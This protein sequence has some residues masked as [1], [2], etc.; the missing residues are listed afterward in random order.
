M[1]GACGPVGLGVSAG[2]VFGGDNN[3]TINEVPLSLD[4]LQA[5]VTVNDPCGLLASLVLTVNRDGVRLTYVLNGGAEQ[6]FTDPLTGNPE[7]EPAAEVGAP[8][9]VLLQPGPNTLVVRATSGADV[10]EQTFNFDRTGTDPVAYEFEPIAV[11][12]NSLDLSWSVPAAA[13]DER[14]FWVYF[15]TAGTSLD[16]LSGTPSSAGASPLRL[17]RQDLA[18]VLVGNRR[19]Y[20]LT[21]EG[22]PSG[23]N[24]SLASYLV[25]VRANDG[26]ESRLVATHTRPAAL[27]GRWPVATITDVP[28]MPVPC[29]GTTTPPPLPPAPV[30]GRSTANTAVGMPPLIVDRG[31]D[32]G[33]G[34]VGADGA[35]EILTVDRSGQLL[36]HENQGLAANGLAAPILVDDVDDS[37]R[38]CLGAGRITGPPIRSISF[39]QDGDGRADVFVLTPQRIWI[40]FGDDSSENQSNTPTLGDCRLLNFKKFC[41]SFVNI[42]DATGWQP[43]DEF[44]DFAVADFDGDGAFDIAATIGVPETL[45]AA[46]SAR[47]LHYWFANKDSNGFT[48]WDWPARAPLTVPINSAHG[49]DGMFVAGDLDGDGRDDILGFEHSS[50]AIGRYRMLLSRG[51]TQAPVALTSG[52]IDAREENAR[53]DQTELVDVDDDGH[54]DLVSLRADELGAGLGAVTRAMIYRIVPGLGIDT[55]NPLLEFNL[56]GRAEGRQRGHLVVRDLDGDGLQDFAYRSVFTANNGVPFEESA[57]FYY[58]GLRNP[59]TGRQDWTSFDATVNRIDL[60]L[61]PPQEQPH[62]HVAIGDLDADGTLDFAAVHERTTPPHSVLVGR[63]EPT[64]VYDRPARALAASD[65]PFAGTLS[66]G[67]GADLALPVD[68]GRAIITAIDQNGVRLLPARLDRGVPSGGFGAESTLTFPTPLS[69][70]L[71][72]VAVGE[73][74]G[75]SLVGL[76][77]N[78]ALVSIRVRGGAATATEGGSVALQAGAR[79]F[80]ARLDRDRANDAVVWDGAQTIHLAATVDPAGSGNQPLRIVDQRMFA[81]VPEFVHVADTD[82]GPASEVVAILPTG[83]ATRDVEIWKTSQRQ[84]T[85]EPFLRPAGFANPVVSTIDAEVASMA[86]TNAVGRTGVDADRR[87]WLIVGTTDGRVLALRRDSFGDLQAAAPLPNVADLGAGSMRVAAADFDNDTI[88]DLIAYREGDNVLSVYRNTPD[89]SEPWRF[90]MPGAYQF[91]GSGNYESALIVPLPDAIADW[92]IGPLNDDPLDDLLL[93]RADGSGLVFFYRQAAQTT[94]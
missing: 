67:S 61:F 2:S 92:R 84:G 91:Q 16:D 93:R 75:S 80:A 15:G 66:P 58:R 65:L 72:D 74:D 68:G 9:T 10:A 7:P 62:V 28:Y 78:G 55:A 31:T 37:T 19:R 46:G 44:L 42:E 53:W 38:P 36:V 57:L 70:P 5:P 32:I 41:G 8:R 43:G 3:T 83:G 39:D 33:A 12:G 90:P 40:Y 94:R 50:S 88:E 77:A 48:N 25:G 14:F 51:R 64:V 76:L 11:R 81:V 71:L 35:R 23:P 60:P 89:D 30:G 22:L 82:D 45:A 24:G 59:T 4:A 49:D 29:D 85:G 86:A 56:N 1:V 47:S 6:G 18:P 26:C 52:D 79:V 17:T 13:G 87:K 27:Q 63:G 73:V 21:L 34:R 69:A 54:L 20:T